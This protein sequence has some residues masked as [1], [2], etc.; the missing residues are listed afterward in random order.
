MLPIGCIVLSFRM[1]TGIR[2]QERMVNPVR[3]VAICWCDILDGVIQ[4]TCASVI[5]RSKMQVLSEGNR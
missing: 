5:S 4:A 2:H 1:R 3:G